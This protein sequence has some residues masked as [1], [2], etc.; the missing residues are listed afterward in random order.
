MAVAVIAQA[1]RLALDLPGDLS[2]AGFDDT[3]SATA[4]W[5]QLTT[6][7]QPVSRMAAEAV[8]ILAARLDAVRAG[9]ACGRADSHEIGSEIVL[10]ESVAPPPS[11]G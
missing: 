11:T 5:P 9:E 7:R 6:V 4:V 3:Q 8:G 1:H 10:R 2:V